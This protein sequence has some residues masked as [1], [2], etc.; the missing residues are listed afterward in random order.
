MPHIIQEHDCC[1]M[2]HP[3]TSPQ[4]MYGSHPC[5]EWHSQLATIGRTKGFREPIPSWRWLGLPEVGC[6][7]V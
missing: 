2:Q 4:S 5:T 1:C 7:A 3:C 6:W